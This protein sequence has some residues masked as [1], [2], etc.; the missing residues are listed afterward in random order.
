MP[1]ISARVAD[2]TDEQAVVLEMKPANVVEEFRQRIWQDF[3]LII[4]FLYGRICA[5][6]GVQS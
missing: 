2:G 6:C 1:D 4:L 3:D 5:S